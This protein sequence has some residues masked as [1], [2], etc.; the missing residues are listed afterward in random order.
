MA[1]LAPVAT[2][3]GGS[4][5]ATAASVGGALVSG[6]SAISQ[7]NY[8]S[9]VARNNAEI[10]RQNA[11]RA[12]DAAQIEQQRSD[13]QYA[14]AGAQA[15]AEQS[16]SGLDV[17]G[18]S[19]LRV[20]NQFGRVRMQAAQDIR[21]QGETTTQNFQNDAANYD[22]AASNYSKQA[23]L[24]GIGTAFNVGSAFGSTATP[25]KSLLG[26]TKRRTYPWSLNG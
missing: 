26:S 23:T 16:A 2:F 11:A 9:A 10:A 21:R 25:A 8:Q 13:Q 4:T 18:G 24:A 15:L 19:Q 17:L 22:A 3:L 7:A 1:F 12:S 6:I 14:A 5:F 20:R